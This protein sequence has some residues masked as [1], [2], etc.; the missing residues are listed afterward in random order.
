MGRSKVASAEKCG[1]VEG[2]RTREAFYP[3]SSVERCISI[4]NHLYSY[5]H[6]NWGYVCS[7]ENGPSSKVVEN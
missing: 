7:F 4:A 3:A 2:W 5:S 6:R 1:R